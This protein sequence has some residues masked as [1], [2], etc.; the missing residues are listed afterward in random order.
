MTLYEMSQAAQTLYDLYDNEEIDEKVV[1]DTLEGMGAE[2][3][4]EDYCKVIRQL[5]SETEQFKAE[6]ARMKK[7]QASL[8]KSVKRL[9]SALLNNMDATRQKTAKAGVFSIR[10]SESK[11]VNITDEKQLP[12][13]FLIEQP[14]KVDKGGIRKLLMTGKTLSGA[15]LQINRNIQIK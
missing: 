13:E 9:N 6:A 14:A 12:K 11:A 5:E 1:K 10:V 8:E 7:R 15:E 2:I 3:K 4:L